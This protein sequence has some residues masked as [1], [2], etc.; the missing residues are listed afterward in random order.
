MKKGAERLKVIGA[1]LRSLNSILRKLS[2]S[3]KI[4]KSP[5]P[6][7]E[8]QPHHHHHTVDHDHDH[9]HMNP[10]IFSNGQSSTS[11]S[12]D[13]PSSTFI[14]GL[15]LKPIQLEDSFDFKG[16]PHFYCTPCIVNF[17]VSKLQDNADWALQCPMTTCTG[18][19][20]PDY[21][22]PIL[23]R[24]VFDSWMNA[25]CYQIEQSSYGAESSNS[26]TTFTCDFC[27]E[28][29]HLSD[30]FSVKDCSHFYCHQ[31]IVNFVVSKLEDNVT[32][33][34]CPE[35]G[36]RGVLDLQYC[37]P[38]LPKD[39]LDWWGKALCEN[40]ILGSENNDKY[41]YCPFKDCSALLVVD[42]PEDEHDIYKSRC[43]HCKREVCLNCK[44]PWHTE[45]NCDKFQKLRDKGEDEMVKELAK[46]KKWSKCPK[47]NYYVE[48]KEGCTYIK[49]RL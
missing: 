11:T 31:C 29:K 8:N 2:L 16:C 33:I 10:L 20:D 28:E 41:F 19:L 1:V 7:L 45:F 4:T 18:T 37:Q 47:C 48:K 6:S 36:C 3:R 17:V 15:C 9:D 39:V 23:P 25:L 38:I 24:Q 44:V 30:S 22:R 34:V 43:P 27:V 5:S 14:C 12:F 13:I 42:D 46:K 35:P 32:S 26:G 21:C 49:C 40:V